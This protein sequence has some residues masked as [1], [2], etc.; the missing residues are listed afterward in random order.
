MTLG[1]PAPGPDP[2]LT[3]VGTPEAGSCVRK[4]GEAMGQSLLSP[5]KD[6]LPVLSPDPL[7]PSQSA[8]A[9]PQV[10]GATSSAPSVPH[11]HRVKAAPG[12]VSLEPGPQ[13]SARGSM[14]PLLK[15]DPTE[16]G[17]AEG[18]GSVASGGT[19]A[20]SDHG[21]EGRLPTT[22]GPA[23]PKICSHPSMS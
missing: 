12:K 7:S 9:R 21:P 5:K 14:E 13:G 1:R 17:S 20:T 3:L 2:V 23:P 4:S 19:E 10:T 18:T 15:P 11:P 8:S 22:K 6:P 16:G